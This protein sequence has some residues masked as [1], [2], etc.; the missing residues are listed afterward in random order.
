[1]GLYCPL[2][3]DNDCTCPAEIYC[4]PFGPITVAAL[5]RW[6]FWP[7]MYKYGLTVHSY[8]T[9]LSYENVFR[10]EYVCF[11]NNKLFVYESFQI[12]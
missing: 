11:E 4:T 9:L 1:M 6:E 8:C 12:I 7:H 10:V 2:V 5:F 3:A